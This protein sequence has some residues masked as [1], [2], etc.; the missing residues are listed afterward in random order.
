MGLKS[1]ADPIFHTFP[2]ARHRCNLE[3]WALAQSRGDGHRSFVTPE[4]GLSEF[5]KDLIWI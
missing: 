4:R 5:N 2:A 3:D 1:R